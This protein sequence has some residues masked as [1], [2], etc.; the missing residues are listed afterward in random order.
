MILI[1]IGEFLLDSCLDRAVRECNGIGAFL[2]EGNPA[3]LDFSGCGEGSE[4]A[5]GVA[6]RLCFRQISP[7]L[8]PLAA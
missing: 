3:S 1:M 5:P 8:K 6:V 7:A 4:A 2:A